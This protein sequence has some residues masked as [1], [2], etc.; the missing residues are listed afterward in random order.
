DP[1]ARIAFMHPVK[2]RAAITRAYFE[3]GVRTFS[4]DCQEELA[5]I[6]DATGGASDLNLVVRMAVSADGAAYSLS[7]KFGVSPDQA[8]A[9]L[10]A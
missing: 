6:L 9:L 10:L 1:D 7:G 8:P 4:L 2:S 3:H 5:K